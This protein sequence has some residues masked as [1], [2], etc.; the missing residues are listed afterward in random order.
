MTRF[1]DWTSVPTKTRA[2]VI[3]SIEND[4]HVF[5]TEHDGDEVLT[6]HA[7]AL[8]CLVAYLRQIEP[9]IERQQARR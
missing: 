2:L 3:D 5:E 4:Q 6:R 9:T 8:R 7:A 1:A